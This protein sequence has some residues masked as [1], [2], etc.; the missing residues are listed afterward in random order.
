MT[1]LGVSHSGAHD[2]PLRRTA[3]AVKRAVRNTQQESHLQFMPQACLV[4]L[5]DHAR[6]IELYKYLFGTGAWRQRRTELQEPRQSFNSS[7]SSDW[8]ESEA[9]GFLETCVEKTLNTPRI[10]LL[11]LFLYDRGTGCLEAFVHWLESQDA[12]IPFPA[13]ENLPLTS[14]QVHNLFPDEDDRHFVME[15]Q[16]AFAPFIFRE[17]EHRI[18]KLAHHRRPYVSAPLKLKSGSYGTVSQV[19]IAAGH[20]EYYHEGSN[21]WEVS[22][23]D[24]IFALKTFRSVDFTSSPNQAYENEKRFL[25]GLRSNSNSNKMIQLDLGGITIEETDGQKIPSLLFELA[26][27]DLK[28]FFKNQD[29]AEKHKKSQSSLLKNAV[30]ILEALD[31]LHSKVKSL[32]L[33]IKPSNIL[34]FRRPDDE[35]GVLWKLSDFNLS[36]KKVERKDD[37]FLELSHT[38]SYESELP[39]AR[40]AGP[41]QAPEIQDSGTLLDEQGSRA[42]E[43]SD[44]WSMGCILLQLLAFLHDGPESVKDLENRLEVTIKGLG[45]RSLFYVT[46]RAEEW[47]GQTLSVRCLIQDNITS[48]IGTITNDLKAMV[49]PRVI[50][51]ANTTWDNASDDER[52]ALT[53]G[54]KLIFGKILVINKDDRIKAADVA[55]KLKKVRKA[56]KTLDLSDNRLPP[57]SRVVEHSK[58]CIVINDANVD[59]HHIEAKFTELANDSLSIPKQCPRCRAYLLHQLLQNNCY[60]ALETHIRALSAD[61]MNVRAL[62]SGQTAISIACEGRGDPLALK[63]LFNHHRDSIQIPTYIADRRTTMMPTAK[64]IID[65]WYM[66]IVPLNTQPTRST[67]STARGKSR[68][69]FSRIIEG[70]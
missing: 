58:I 24:K 5:F 33:D 20:Y 38:E 46:D 25:N 66:P 28:D 34:V 6:L 41:Y 51:W 52:L 39:S 36:Q 67:T 40:P 15:N 32:R 23:E 1:S 60:R 48:D 42:S 45:K 8:S 47:R 11:A 22:R 68:S 9:T 37:G 4:D 59:S 63:V 61:D 12:N 26:V 21:S 13:D 18:L 49:H 44:V 30:D 56:Y 64:K 19:T 57:C 31:F 27:C 50:E 16:A 55:K 43:A 69:W 35:N 3:S 65:A 70:F 2:S 54:F 14:E 7:D 17:H 29:D 62:G 10:S 53:E